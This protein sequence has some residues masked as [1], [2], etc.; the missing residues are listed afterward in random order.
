MKKTPPLIG[1]NNLSPILSETD[2]DEK[3][4]AVLSEIDKVL[5]KDY[6]KRRQT[7][8][9]RFKVT[10]QA[11]QWS[12]KKDIDVDSMNKA[13]NQLLDA[14]KA[15]WMVLSLLLFLSLLLL[16]LLVVLVLVLV[17]LLLLL[18]FCW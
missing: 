11:F 17:L 18:V 13:R 4:M 2:L 9:T 15:V 3:Q 12:E 1:S 16:L 10:M 6:A 8:L 5:C 7:M 14:I